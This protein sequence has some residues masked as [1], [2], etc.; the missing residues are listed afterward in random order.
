MKQLNKTKVMVLSAMFLAI[1]FILP[2][3]TGQIQQ[4][5]SMLCPMHLP[6]IL[7][8]FLCGAPWGFLV[9]F[10]AP[11]LRSMV[12]GMPPMFPQAICMAFELATYGLVAGYLYKILPKKKYNIYS[13][14]IVAM[15]LGR[16]VWGMAMYLC[17]GISGG[18]FGMEAF[19]AGALTN[20][21]PGIIIQIILIPVLVMAYEKLK[22]KD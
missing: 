5:G 12:L 18:Q 10:L 8:G 2:F 11:V 4:I 19:L 1:A 13:A 21:I 15:I 3:L 14:L 17:V 9:G 6:V 7:C 16:I 20:A 22:Q